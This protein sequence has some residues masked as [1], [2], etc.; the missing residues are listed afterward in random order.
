MMIRAVS[1][2]QHKSQICAEKNEVWH[3]TLKEEKLQVC[4]I[5]AM[6]QIFHRIETGANTYKLNTCD[7]FD[8]GT[9]DNGHVVDLTHFDTGIYI[10]ALF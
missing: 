10:A 1:Q 9:D 4:Q 6:M 3:K 5:G 8:V 7:I 2:R